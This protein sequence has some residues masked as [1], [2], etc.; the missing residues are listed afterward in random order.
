MAHGAGHAWREGSQACAGQLDSTKRRREGALAAARCPAGAP[1]AAGQPGGG[2]RGQRRDPAGWACRQRRQRLRSLGGIPVVRPALCCDAVR[3][4]PAFGRSQGDYVIVF[5][6][7]GHA[8]LPS[9]WI[10]G[11]W[12][13]LPRPFRKHV[14][15]IVLVRPSGEG[16]VCR[17]LCCAG[18]CNEGQGR[19][20]RALRSGLTSGWWRPPAE[21]QRSP[22]CPVLPASQ[23][24]LHAVVALL[25][26]AAFLR[27][28][29]AFM[30]PFVS[31]KAGR[32]IKQVRARL[33]RGLGR[34]WGG[35]WGTVAASC[36]DGC[37]A[38]ACALRRAS[39]IPLLRFPPDVASCR[40]WQAL[41]HQH[42]RPPRLPWAPGT[43]AVQVQSVHEIAAATEGEVTVQ[44]LGAAFA[45]DLAADEELAAAA[46]DAS[47]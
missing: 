24:S 46:G 19:L 41:P 5:T 31:K 11:A 44:S 25:H 29:L 4:P 18:P 40:P 21:A 37:W 1:G 14:Q 8:K 13:S 35:G 45:A 23:L 32:K 3:P 28:V 33:A 2:W 38:S 34:G 27:A 15:Y 6:S 39:P 16:G 26:V 17:L 36:G 30:R 20:M 7:R 12:R 43:P 22:P 10:M 42:R 9:M 47:P